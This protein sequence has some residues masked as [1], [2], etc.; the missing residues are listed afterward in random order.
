M[1]Q[2]FTIQEPPHIVELNASLNLEMLWVEPGTFTLGTPTSEANRETDE[3]E[4]QVT[5][6]RGFYMGKYDVTQAEY[7]LVMEGNSDGIDAT[8]SNFPGYSDRPVERVKY[9]DAQKFVERLNDQMASSIP[10]GWAY[11]LP[12]EAQWEY[13]CRA[14]T[15][16][17]YSWGDS[18]A[19][20]NAN[21]N[22]D[23]DYNSGS[24]YQQ[25][26]DVGQYSPNNWGFY[27][28]HGNV[29][30]W[31]SDWYGEYATGPLT[32]PSGADS[33][34]ERVIRGGAWWDTGIYLRSGDRFSEDLSYVNGGVGFRIAFQ[35]I[36]NAPINLAPLASLSIAEN[37]SV[38]TIVGEFN[39]SDP[40][41]NS[42]SYFLVSGQGDENNSLFLLEQ[43]G[44][45]ASSSIIDFETSEPIL[46]IRVQARD[47]LNA[48]IEGNFSVSLIDLD[49]EAPVLSLVGSSSITHEAGQLYL[50]DNASW[51]D[52]VD[53]SGS[54]TATGSVDID[55]PG[56][57]VLSY[58]YTDTSGNAAST[59]TR[60]V[61]VVDTTAPV[62]SLN[63]DAS[64]TH[65][66]GQAYLDDNATWSDHVDG[67]ESITATGSVD[68]D[69]PG[70][71]V[72]S[73]NYTDTSGNAA[74]TV[75]RT[76]TVV[77]TTAPVISLN[78]DESVT[79]EA[80]QL[81][82][83][84][85]ATWSDHVDGSESITATGSVDIDTPGS[86]V[87][88]YN[89]TDTSG[90]A[91]S[92]VTRTVT[93][94]DTTA[95]VITL[96]GDAS[97]THEAGQL[98][99]DD[100][101]TWSDHV[102]GSESITATGSV[103][104]DTPGSYMLSYNYTDTSG[105]AASTVTRTVTVVDTTAPVISLNGDESVTHEAGQLYL[106]ENATWSDHVDGSESIT[107]TGSVDIDTPGSY[108]LS[109]NYTDTSGNAASTVTRT[110]TVVD[111]T[112]PVISLNGDVSVTHEAGQLY[113]DDNATWSDHVDGS[114][115]IT[116]T[117]SVDIDT[118][119]SYVLSYNYTDTS[120][121]AASTV[122]R[123]VTVV[124]TTAPVISLNGDVSV[125]HEAGQLYLDDNATWSDHVDGSGSITATGS[126]DIDTPGSYVLSYNYTDTSGNAAST[127]TRTV[128][129]VDTTA[130]VISLNGDVSVSHEAGQLYL[131]DNAT[132]SDHVDGSESITATGSVDIDTPGSYVLSYNYTDTSGNA[133]STVT[134]TVT[135][136][137]TTA[138]VISLNGDVSVTHEA[139]QLYLDDNATW[140]DHVDGS[141]SITATGSVDIDTP[142]SYMLS[143]NY[144]D[145]SGNA[146]STVTRTVT[147]V[148]TTAPL[149]SLNGDVSVSHE[150]GQ[151]YLD[152]NATWSDHVDGS[153]SITATGSV[154]IDTPGSYML[155]YNYTDTSG[156]AASTVTRTVTVV[157]TT[158][159]VI[160]LNGDVSVTHEA[161]QLYLDDNATWSDHVDGSGS[162]T[163]T[164]SVDIDT[165][166]SYVLS[167]NYTDTSGNAA[168]TVTRTVTVV[169]TTAPV[170]S[171]NGDVSVSHEAGQAYLDD[172]ATWSDHVDGSES[173]TATGSV[174]I[175][176]PGSYMLSYNY[177]DT[178]GNAASTVT[179]TVTVVDTTAPVI[180]L[181][182]DAVRY[183]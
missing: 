138:P 176:T 103:D 119:G 169:D 128:T 127:V 31:V 28:M 23:G 21:Y 125:T 88:S 77:D 37:Q 43:N 159:P 110:V 183:S 17:V 15:S 86:Y 76:V 164:G 64:V 104:I 13:A 108:V 148:D 56:S 7:E 93:V 162:I 65:E 163:A 42:I 59:V 81:Y 114:E 6:S 51:V 106:D 152:E 155:S 32:D 121:N 34:S 175:D 36:N 174:D 87:L 158:A 143:Y 63:G 49:D 1:N 89:Y 45:L 67:S 150:A 27:D 112:A 182:G 3:T 18:I 131:D 12:T 126:V 116:A 161:G 66:A 101:A 11:V 95:P 58:N 170:I 147:V 122:T 40:D 130:P 82:L 20:N 71:Y 123:T 165:P 52:N 92:T 69:T 120:G 68:I 109:Y 139:G 78:G 111:T 44:T 84:D 180:S 83:D 91:A 85:N 178:S 39:S 79:H 100:N 124:D 54:I 29:R 55:T 5:F 25:T 30:E 16:T 35:D 168:S 179:R 129:V 62:I 136:V 4:T 72:L 74:S 181:N 149:I 118:P 102:D 50:D 134:R 105:N 99:L 171:L 90:N 156:N 57:Y 132:W 19:S 167:Y 172:N 146:A 144:T 154:D 115:S 26:R 41:G 38:G 53:G 107:A 22:W 46:S 70:S 73:Y 145:T 14:G 2:S 96:N 98:Y 142:G 133:A 140:V 157:D 141:G 80:G 151:A 135:V 8:P 117:G 160:S 173:I 97:V 113:L 60:T 9:G 33:G 153:E 94:V 47:E 48:S 166:G 24:D 177:T 137:D 61:T 10:A 75:T